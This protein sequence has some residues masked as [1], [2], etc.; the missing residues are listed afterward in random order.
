MKEREEQEGDEKRRR[1]ESKGNFREF[2]L[3]D[4]GRG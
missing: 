2:V 3:E 1:D 4:E